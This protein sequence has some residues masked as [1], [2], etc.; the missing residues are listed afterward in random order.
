MESLDLNRFWQWWKNEIVGLIPT[1]DILRSASSAATVEIYICTDGVEVHR[2]PK[3]ARPLPTSLHPRPLSEVIGDITRGDRVLITVPQSL[4]LVRNRTVPKAVL[5]KLSSVLALDLLHNTPFAAEGVF[6]GWFKSG[7][8]DEHGMQPISQVILKRSLVGSVIDEITSRKAQAVGIAVRAGRA[9]AYPCVSAP[10]GQPFGVLKQQ[11]WLRRCTVGAA[12][13]TMMV[14][15]AGFAAF[16]KQNE[17][18]RLLN[19]EIEALQEPTKLARS[20]LEAKTKA[21]EQRAE[22]QQLRQRQF[23]TLQVVEELSRLLPDGAWVQTLLKDG[24]VI[25][26]EGQADL[27]EPL[28]PLLE[29]SP[30]FRD[31]KFT[32]PVFKAAGEDKTVQFSMSLGLENP[33]P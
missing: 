30:L 31:A 12:A 6:S 3:L 10:D 22:L 24:D 17:A 14:L 9:A 23:P 16:A 21:A 2:K 26:I 4:C 29:A 1:E 33:E 8:A 19:V 20:A 32:S 18:L 27:A 25:R 13:A 28:I 15:V 11:L 7:V 5:P